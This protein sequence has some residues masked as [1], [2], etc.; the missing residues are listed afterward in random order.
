VLKPAF[1][2]LLVLTIL[3]VSCSTAPSNHAPSVSV[4][5]S[6]SKIGVAPI[7]V[8]VL[9]SDRD[10][11]RLSLTWS[12]ENG[13]VSST[14]PSAQTATYTPAT[15]GPGSMT[16]RVEDGRGGSASATMSFYVQAG[17]PPAFTFQFVPCSDCL[18][19]YYCA[20]LNMIS[21]ESVLITRIDAAHAFG[22]VPGSPCREGRNSSQLG[23]AD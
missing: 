14:S 4:V 23:G 17:G 9:A 10:G 3:L 22:L 1:I 13:T 21:N 19:N 5:T 2:G 8:E 15:S 11:D 12:T 6:L 7:S 18:P 20:T 16:V